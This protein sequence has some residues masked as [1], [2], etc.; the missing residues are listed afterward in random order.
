[1]KYLLNVVFYIID[2]QTPIT[3]NKTRY[4]DTVMPSFFARI[5]DDKET[6]IDFPV[7]R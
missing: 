7:T 3:S 5:S 6:L 2:L 1:M 4:S